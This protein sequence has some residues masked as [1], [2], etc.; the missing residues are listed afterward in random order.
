MNRVY[1]FDMVPCKIEPLQSSALCP[2]SK[3]VPTIHIIMRS[4][5]ALWGSGQNLWCFGL[6]LESTI[7]R[8]RG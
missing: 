7:G 2:Y 8:G 3:Y 1:S 4:P 6:K 5:M